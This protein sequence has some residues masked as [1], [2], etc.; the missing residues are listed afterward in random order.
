MARRGFLDY[1]LGGAVGG[2]EGLA[3]KRAAE[4]ERKR[5][6]DAA[7][8]DQAR[9]LMQ[10]N[11]R[12]APEAVDTTQPSLSR[13]SFGAD[14][15]ALDSRT[16]RMT[17]VLGRGQ[18]ARAAQEAIAAS[19]TLP[20]GQKVRFNAPESAAQIAAKKLTEDETQ[21]RADAVKRAFL[22]NAWTAAGATP[23]QAIA[24]ANAGVNVPA[25]RLAA[26]AENL[27]PWQKQGFASE[28][29]FRAYESRNPKTA[30]ASNQPTPEELA[31]AD[32]A[33]ADPSL[34]PFMQPTFNA[35]RARGDKRSDAVLKLAV[36]RVLRARANIPTSLG[37]ARE[38]SGFNFL[39]GGGFGSNPA[40]AG[41]PGGAAPAAR[42]A[43]AAP[44]APVVPPKP[45]PAPIADQALE[46][47]RRLY[48]AGVAKHGSARMLAEYGKRP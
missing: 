1:V 47:D 29:E 22:V 36:W 24:Y 37:G 18:E 11:Y 48:D 2:L 16:T 44:I 12:V 19:V 43:P 30:S 35:L 13:P 6:A 28:A 5:M 10:L 38:S 7:A 21:K 9:L 20:S 34:A 40:A 23:E 46:E 26:P 45:A 41:I 14:P 33:F 32:A 31:E 39:T 8:M 4:E 42:V 27:K 15:L 3:Q 17:E 25:N